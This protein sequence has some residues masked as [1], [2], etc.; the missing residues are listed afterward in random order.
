MVSAPFFSFFK[1]KNQTNKNNPILIS[2]DV[3]KNKFSLLLLL[4]FSSNCQSQ[5][6]YFGRVSVR[7]MGEINLIS[8]GPGVIKPLRALLGEGGREG[9]F[10]FTVCPAVGMGL[11]HG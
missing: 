11:R 8:P 3:K 2:V 7:L 9:I 1:E 10:R 4:S 6:G 5:E